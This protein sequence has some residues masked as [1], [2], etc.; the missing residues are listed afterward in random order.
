M[1]N[2]QDYVKTAMHEAAL[3]SAEADAIAEEKYRRKLQKR[4]DSGYWKKRRQEAVTKK[5]GRPRPDV[6][7]ICGR[8][9]PICFDHNHLN[10]AFRG[11]LCAGCNAA[12]GMAHDDPELLRKLA[13]YL[14]DNSGVVAWWSKPPEQVD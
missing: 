7:E 6:C 14:E 3:R 4:E 12:L 5:A 13:L 11:W 10:G 8:S 2:I 9:G 1:I